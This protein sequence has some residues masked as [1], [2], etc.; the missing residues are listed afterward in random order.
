MMNVVLRT[1]KVPW[2]RT[3]NRML[4]DYDDAGRRLAAEDVE[5]APRTG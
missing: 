4:R 1:R 3:W 5:G 2:E